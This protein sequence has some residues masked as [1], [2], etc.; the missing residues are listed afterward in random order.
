M[1]VIAGDVMAVKTVTFYPGN[2]ELGLHTH[3]AVVELLRRSTGEPLAVMDGRLITEMRTA[4]VS[5]VALDA[6]GSGEIRSLGILGSGVQ[7]RAH[8]Q[9][10]CKVRPS[11]KD[12][13]IWSRTPANAESL[14]AEYRRACGHD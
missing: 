6:L 13:R 9:A 10:L 12:I 1:P 2:A 5:A 7:A 14:A 3:M 8:M 4:A 11:L